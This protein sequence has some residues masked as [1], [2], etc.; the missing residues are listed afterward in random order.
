MQSLKLIGLVFTVHLCALLNGAKT[1]IHEMQLSLQPFNSI[2]RKD[3]YHF[4]V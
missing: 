4:A 3:N 1:S 2:P